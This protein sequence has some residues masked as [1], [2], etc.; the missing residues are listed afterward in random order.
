MIDKTPY[1]PGMREVLKLSKAEAGRLGNDYIG[2]EHYLL[3]LLRKGDG[4]ALQALM[5]LEVELDDLKMEIE[6]LMQAEGPPTVGLFSP[7]AEAKQALELAKQTASELKHGWVG[8]EHLLLG[9]LRTEIGISFKALT[10]FGVDFAKAKEEVLKVIEGANVDKFLGKR[11]IEKAQ[12]L[13]AGNTVWHVFAPELVEAFARAHHEMVRMRHGVCG[14]EHLLLA[15]L[16]LGGASCERLLTMLAS[17]PGELRA[18]LLPLIEAQAAYKPQTGSPTHP[19]ILNAE[20]KRVLGTATWRAGSQWGGMRSRGGNGSV[21][22]QHLLLALFT[23]PETRAM[24]LLRG[25][26]PQMDEAVQHFEAAWR[27]GWQ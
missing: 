15:V 10:S 27:M 14:S 25:E 22:T 3:G 8:S 9:I 18:K 4:L 12:A 19:E 5:N 1:T 13:L 23:E 20:A 7:N 24:A 2:T 16:Q 17:S 21:E 26:F 11:E 6:R